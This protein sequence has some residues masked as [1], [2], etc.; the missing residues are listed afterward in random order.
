MAERLRLA[1][2]RYDKDMIGPYLTALCKRNT[3]EASQAEF[4][5]EVR[6]IQQSV[7]Q[8]EAT[9]NEWMICLR[10]CVHESA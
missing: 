10:G 7:K 4:A 2:E 5:Q 6:H 3:P 9:M 1:M 8:G